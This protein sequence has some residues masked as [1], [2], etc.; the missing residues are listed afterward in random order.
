MIS[1]PY[2]YTCTCFFSLAPSL[3]FS[4][5]L[6][7][8]L[9]PSHLPLPPHLLTSLS[10]YPSS[11]PHLS[12]SPPS[13]PLSLYPL[14]SSLYISPYLSSPTCKH[15][16]ISQCYYL[17][18]GKWHGSTYEW[19]PVA[20]HQVIMIFLQVSSTSTC[21]WTSYNCDQCQRICV[22]QTEHQLTPQRREFITSP[23][24]EHGRHGISWQLSTCT[25]SV[26]QV[27]FLLSLLCAWEQV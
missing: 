25:N 8:P 1:W 27:L 9:I 13:S 6:S 22:T 18:V 2:S 14:F 15:H 7:L 11:P 20:S 17:T 24:I 12:P 21:G 10:L 23:H 4:F 5:S 26:Y 16:C 19:R 3:F